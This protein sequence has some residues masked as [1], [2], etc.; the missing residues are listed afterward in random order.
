MFR[1]CD[2]EEIKTRASE[3]ST[4]IEEKKFGHDRGA[5]LISSIVGSMG[6]CFVFLSLA[7]RIL[8]PWGFIQVIILTTS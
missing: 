2:S 7:D 6:A 5:W 4:K 3:T 8:T 1:K